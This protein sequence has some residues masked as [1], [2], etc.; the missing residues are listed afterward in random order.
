MLEVTAISCPIPAGVF[1]PS[2]MLGAGFGRLY[3]YCLKLIFGNAI[4][5]ATYA[6]IGAA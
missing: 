2:F 3:G 4:N 1:F 5:E 6:I